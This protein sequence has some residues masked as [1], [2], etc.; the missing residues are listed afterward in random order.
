[1]A[2]CR[3]QRLEHRT[4]H[5]ALRYFL[6]RELQQ[7]G[8][9]RLAYVASEANTDDVFTKA[10]APCDH[11]RCCTQLAAGG[12]GSHDCTAAA[13]ADHHRS[14]SAAQRRDQLRHCLCRLRHLL[15]LRHQCRCRSLHHRHR[16][17]RLHCCC[18]H[19]HPRHHPHHHPHPLHCLHYHL[20]RP[21]HPHERPCPPC[22]CQC[23]GS[24]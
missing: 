7:R 18:R 19:L 21:R 12:R 4:K 8:Q 2:L 1:M 24:R 9:L 10:L 20:H 14:H 3:E 16:R 6:A 23:G 17:R 5:I 22:S 15:R 11:Q 13:G